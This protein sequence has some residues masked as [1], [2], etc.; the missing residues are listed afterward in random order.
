VIPVSLKTTASTLSV[1]FLLWNLNGCAQVATQSRPAPEER[2]AEYASPPPSVREAPEEVEAPLPAGPEPQAEIEAPVP[3]ALE[4]PSGIDLPA[5]A[6]PESK[7]AIE[8]PGPVR[9]EAPEE[10]EALP[11]KPE[12]W[13]YVHVVRWEGETLSRIAEWYTGSWKNWE[14][15]ARANSRI[16]PDR[17]LLGNRIQ[18]PASLLKRREPMPREFTPFGGVEK[19]T[20]RSSPARVRPE[21]PH[22]RPVLEA[23]RSGEEQKA[24]SEKIELFGPDAGSDKPRALPE[25]VELFG[26]GEIAGSPETIPEKTELFGPVE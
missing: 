24:L 21:E 17:I 1:L 19:K 4:T 3:A 10:V 20:A 11:V 8:V 5:P 16:D 14:A 26:P 12:T 15:I 18:I 2:P 23:P 22:T 25:P 13:F 9:P 7:A 6:V